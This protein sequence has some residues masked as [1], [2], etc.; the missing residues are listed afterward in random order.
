MLGVGRRCRCRRNYEE[1]TAV[2]MLLLS[3]ASGIWGKSVRV[4]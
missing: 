4:M 1:S 3:T 2:T